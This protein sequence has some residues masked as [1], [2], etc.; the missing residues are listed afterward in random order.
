[1]LQVLA[2]TGWWD[3]VPLW[4]AAAHAAIAADVATTASNAGAG[5]VQKQS[6]IPSA[7]GSLLDELLGVQL[8][9]RHPELVPLPTY[10]GQ[11]QQQGQQPSQQHPQEGADHRTSAAAEMVRTVAAVMQQVPATYANCNR[12]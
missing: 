9:Q 2:G 4:L 10:T 8:R 11:Q 6:A 1:M 3:R 5:G 7:A 12:L